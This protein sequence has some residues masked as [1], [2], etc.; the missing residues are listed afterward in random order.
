[1]FRA[2]EERNYRLYF[3]GQVLSNAGTWMQ[4]VA[5]DWLVLDLSGSSAVA[6]GITTALQFLPFLLF[7]LWGGTLA[8]RIPRRKLLVIT[9]IAMGALAIVLG[10][11]AIA[12]LATVA[13]VYVLAF[14]LGVAAAFDN[15]ARQAFVNE[16]VGK[17]RLGN[18]I[19]LN[20][21]SFNLARLVGP[22]LAGVLVA[23]VGSGWVFILNGLSFAVT[24][25]ALLAMRAAEL[26]PQKRQDGAVKLS[27]G[28]R[29]VGR[30]ADL[31]L[32]LAL[33]FIVA[34][35]GL[36]YQ[37]TMALMARNQ[38][39]V[40]AEAFGIMSTAL[41]LGALVGSL[42]AA[43]RVHIPLKLV[44]VAALV[45]GVVEVVNGLA[46]TYV[47]MLVLLPFAGLAAMTFTT[48]AQTY[49]QSRSEGWVRGRVMGVYT[50]LFFGGTPLGAPVIGWAS[51]QWG[52]RIGLVGGGALTF[53][54]SGVAVL[55]YLRHR[56]R[57]LDLDAVVTDAPVSPEPAR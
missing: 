39:G 33:A 46:P 54:I 50:L 22:A 31:V 49:L 9:Q 56:R 47:S 29:Y 42:L 2:L 40:G 8:D 20:S 37:M 13:I 5:Q 25:W 43:R 53:V 32:V 6:L 21:A 19:A 7:S 15:P 48:S 51:E 14:A 45:F 10:V 28:L 52:P 55:V 24:I 3:G 30:N 34:T 11:L 12:G 27:Q 23:V 57:R 38:F 44:V 17:E 4:R 18:A 26:R 16:I 41:A 35:F 1:M 36:N